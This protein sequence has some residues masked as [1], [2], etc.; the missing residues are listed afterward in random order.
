MSIK[1]I[2]V[3]F[4]LDM[5]IFM[6][7]LAHG[8]DAVRFEVY[9]DQ[10]KVPK[11]RKEAQ[12]VDGVKAL[13]KPARAIDAPPVRI[14]LFDYIKANKDGPIPV[15]AMCAYIEQHGYA[16]TSVYHALSA[17]MKA[18]YIKRVDAGVYQIT[19]KGITHG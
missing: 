3:S 2:R 14:V 18:K 17:L 9:G 6:R 7:M 1:K 4:D 8:N 11:V 15:K 16:A 13:P 10:P 12:A 19:E 5:E